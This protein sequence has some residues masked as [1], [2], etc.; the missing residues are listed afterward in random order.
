MN[1][2][3]P[4]PPFARIVLIDE[5][6]KMRTVVLIFF[7]VT[8]AC[9]T[10]FDTKYIT[11]HPDTVEYVQ[12]FK[13]EFNWVNIRTDIFLVGSFNYPVQHL[14]P[15]TLA[16]C[17]SRTLRIEILAS[18]FEELSEES[19]EQLIFHE[20]A[21]C[22]A[23]IMHD[24]TVTKNNFPTSLMYPSMIPDHL[25]TLQRTY[26]IQELASKLARKKQY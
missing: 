11:H 3:K 7:L 26:Y 18:V 16:I 1:L 8:T 4:I 21:H 20:L 23:N 22:E 5:E 17:V 6:T 12:L 13:E 2:K 24:T 14:S 19:K 15:N 10:D 9:G 25:Y